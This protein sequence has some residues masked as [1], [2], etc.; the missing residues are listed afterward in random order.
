M[1][2]DPP[3]DPQGQEPMTGAAMFW[4]TLSIVGLIVETA[5]IIVLGRRATER[6]EPAR[7]SDARA[8]PPRV[9]G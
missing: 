2:F 1:A 4:I 5:L 8:D 7:G 9:T 6:D 3:Q